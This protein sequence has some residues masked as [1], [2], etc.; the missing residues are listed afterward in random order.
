MVEGLWRELDQGLQDFLVRKGLQPTCAPGCWACCQG[1]V[2]TGRLEAEAILPHLDEAARAR[3]LEEGP[4]RLALLRANKDRPD[5][6]LWYYRKRQPCP[7]LREG[8]CTIYPHRPLACRGVLTLGPNDFCKPEAKPPKD[9]F[10]PTAYRMAQRALERLWEEERARYGY[11][12]VG[13][14]VS[15]LYL[16]LRGFPQEK[17][18]A[19][20]LLKGLGLLGGRWGYQLL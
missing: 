18:E 3:V 12:V 5:F 15:L 11:A 10:L 14:L 13:E 1:L 4:K 17:E 9:H 6:P 7:F 16:L 8:L 20:R 19:Q 2:S